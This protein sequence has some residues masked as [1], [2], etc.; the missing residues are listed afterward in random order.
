MDTRVSDS[1]CCHFLTCDDDIC[2]WLR[3]KSITAPSANVETMNA[4]HRDFAARILLLACSALLEAQRERGSFSTVAIVA[5]LAS[6]CCSA[7]TQWLS[8]RSGSTSRLQTFV[9]IVRLGLCV[10]ALWI[11]EFLAY[12][13]LLAFDA[14]K[15]LADF[16]ITTADCRQKTHAPASGRFS[17]KY[18][19]DGMNR[20]IG[21]ARLG[22][23]DQFS[24][25]LKLI[26]V[27][28]WAIPLIRSYWAYTSAGDPPPLRHQ[29]FNAVPALEAGSV[30][31]LSCLAALLG[32]A[33]TMADAEHQSLLQ[34][35]DKMRVTRRHNAAQVKTLR[36]SQ[37]E[38]THVATLR[39]RTRIARE[40]HDNVGH[41]L[42]RALMQT[43]AASAVATAT[44]NQ[45]SAKELSEISASL[46]EAMTM[47]R[48]SVHNL[49]D[50]GTDF[51]AQI[52]GVVDMINAAR[53]DFTVSLDCD[54][55]DTPAP[56][57][58]TL[59]SVIR[60]ALTNVIRHSDT[61]TATVSLHDYPAFW[62]LSVFNKSGDTTHRPIPQNRHDL[63]GMGLATIEQR[64]Q[65]LDGTCLCGPYRDG[66]RVFVSL[67]KAPWA[68]PDRDAGARTEA[69]GDGMTTIDKE[70]TGA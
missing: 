56:V 42:T 20:I 52:A 46:N 70:R 32:H 18:N 65:A 13:Q 66:W 25:W 63:R 64:V 9:C 39:E 60:E 11:P 43:Q 34:L 17:V 38:S 37:A 40:I 19:D 67:P 51:N 16:P 35:F 69:I 45:A 2:H 50:D 62:Q 4:Q 61:S 21:N 1:E 12:T 8:D 57:A 55:T 10:V 7:L 49:E 24:G 30:I 26:T 28:C 68:K 6:I 54:I 58:R 47:V 29:Q 27:W 15:V 53:P 31:L 59:T 33:Y 14:M 44:G 36:D 41:I 5:L 48:R 22:Q 23:I 3:R